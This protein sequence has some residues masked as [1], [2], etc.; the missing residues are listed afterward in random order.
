MEAPEIDLVPGLAGPTDPV[1][2]K[3]GY[4]AFTSAF[5]A[6]VANNAIDTIALC[7]VSTDS[8]VLKTAVDAFERG[9]EPVVFADACANHRSE[10]IHQAALLILS[11]FIGKGQVRESSSVS[12][13]LATAMQPV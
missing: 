5:S 7:G 2:D 10:E 4:T 13:L 12:S 6:F 8:C 3:S 9:I 11:R 1:F